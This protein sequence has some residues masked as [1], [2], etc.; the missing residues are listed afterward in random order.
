[1]RRRI[2]GLDFSGAR[3]C[4]RR[5][6]IAEGV[7]GR[8]GFR[9]AT[10]AC[11]SDCL[12]V[13]A[14]PE[15]VFPALRAHLGVATDAA[16]G[17]DFPVS[18]A[19]ALIGAQGWQA[20]VAGFP[21][22]FA[23]AETFRAWCAT[24]VGERLARRACDLEARTPFAA[25]N[26]R[27]YRQTWSGL[28]HLVGPLVAAGRLAVPPLTPAQADRAW[29]LETCPASVLLHLGLREPYKAADPPA[30]KARR[31]ILDA[32][33]ERRWVEAPMP[34]LRAAMFDDA[35]GDALDAAIAAAAAARAVR[36]A[37]NLVPRSAIETV[38]GRVYFT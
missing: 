32:L 25:H 27:L 5:I 28:A 18:L 9:L 34:A 33:I 3:D 10:L 29:L 1:L 19:A 37:A 23:D 20:F 14:T 21:A 8:R 22:R 17:A 12:N 2:L 4:G 26:L 30:R 13:G 11:A 38:E 6:W 35:G 15:V 36:D 24:Q 31:R 16:I 7:A